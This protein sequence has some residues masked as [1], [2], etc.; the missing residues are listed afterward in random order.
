M[1]I[2]VSIALGDVSVDCQLTASGTLIA[3]CTVTYE[4]VVYP[5]L[6]EVEV[7]RGETITLTTSTSVEDDI[8]VVVE[9]ASYTWHIREARGTKY[10]EGF[11]HTSLTGT[12]KA[13]LKFDD[14][15]EVTLTLGDPNAGAG[16]IVVYMEHNTSSLIVLNTS[17]GKYKSVPLGDVPVGFVIL[18]DDA[19]PVNMDTYI[20]A[21]TRS[22]IIGIDKD[23]NVFHT[24]PLT[25]NLATSHSTNPC[26]GVFHL[27]GD[28]V[29][30]VYAAYPE[31]FV[32][33]IYFTVSSNI[34]FGYR[35]TGAP[36]QLPSGEMYAP[37]H[38]GIKFH[39]SQIVSPTTITTWTLP[40][41]TNDSRI[42]LA[43]TSK[44]L[45]AIDTATSMLHRVDRNPAGTG[46][47]FTGEF[48][49]LPEVPS[50]VLSVEEGG[51]E[52]V[53][54]GYFDNRNVEKY[55]VNLELVETTT[56]G[57]TAHLA[58]IDGKLAST[59]VF[60]D[61]PAVSQSILP[62]AVYVPAVEQKLNKTVT[63]SYVHKA[64]R[65]LFASNMDP[66]VTVTV[67]G[68]AFTG[69]LPKDATIVFTLPASATYYE[70]RT[71]GLLGT[72]TIIVNA[73]VEPKL[74]S[75]LVTLTRM[76]DANIRTDYF[77]EFEV[78]GMTEGFDVVISSSTQ[79][80]EISVNDAPFAPSSTMRLHD[81]VRL[82][83]NMPRLGTS[84]YTV[85]NEVV[86]EFGVTVSTWPILKMELDGVQLISPSNVERIKNFDYMEFDSSRESPAP[87]IGRGDKVGAPIFNL[88][89]TTPS[90]ASTSGL[91]T[92]SSS[93]YTQA[94]IVNILASDGELIRPV[95]YAGS[96]LSYTYAASEQYKSEHGINAIRSKYTSTV[97]A[98]AYTQ[99]VF[100]GVSREGTSVSLT[101]I[102]APSFN[103]KEGYGTWVQSA[104][105]VYYLASTPYN[106]K[107]SGNTYE[108]AAETKYKAPTRRE[109]VP[110]NMRL[111]PPAVRHF[112]SPAVMPRQN[113]ARYFV[114]PTFAPKA[115]T[116]RVVT[117]VLYGNQKG[118][119]RVIVAPAV[120]FNPNAQRAMLTSEFAYAKPQSEVTWYA[121]LLAAVRPAVAPF[122]VE[123]ITDFQAAASVSAVNSDHAFERIAKLHEV[124][125]QLDRVE[126]TR[127]H[128][129]TPTVVFAPSHYRTVTVGEDGL[130]GS[131]AAAEL[132]ATSL[133]LDAP[134]VV[135]QV[136]NVWQV[137]SAPNLANKECFAGQLQLPDK[138]FGYLGGG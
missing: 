69:V 122:A 17:T 36:L 11:G 133:N 94:E 6:A 113:L 86:T 68:T 114:E 28:S 51:E 62:T 126:A 52:F 70:H 47:T 99:E 19:M 111:A 64:D 118:T 10:T 58:M 48:A 20:V 73:Y 81:T 5:P 100:R 25:H 119:T 43:A 35:P 102:Q 105:K 50:S 96:E 33:S 46:N 137:R 103:T 23:Y 3:E 4:G 136:G 129:A 27:H 134:A 80:M 90:A 61:A 124:E 16:Q 101:A 30:L 130:F 120:G 49:Y 56:L 121:D 110:A 98:S 109:I 26:V 2:P 76:Y 57:R 7:R 104:S 115:A 89:Y 39:N 131:H 85:N 112:A 54:I 75:D 12:V 71:F 14:G 116:S 135:E 132:Y 13:P 55:N 38:T 31:Y 72:A 8:A 106:F 41:V 21:V 78:I 53:Y 125:A 95:A 123:S 91:S 59:L 60:A 108:A 29:G 93:V 138:T 87:V 97:M 22:T 107:D 37:I 127:Q 42:T 18:P 24:R 128:L 63:V 74:F 66:S 9:N 15:A 117:D 83:W 32:E 67:N 82:K 79:L 1:F 45:F 92:L 40:E 65:A 44:S 88:E 34:G 84:H 77:D